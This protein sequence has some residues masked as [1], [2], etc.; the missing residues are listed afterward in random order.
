MSSGTVNA[1]QRTDAGLRISSA[2]DRKIRSRRWTSWRIASLAVALPLVVLL[3]WSALVMRGG[4]PLRVRAERLTIATVTRG[5]FQEF[6]PVSSTVVPRTTHYLDAAEGGRVE[7]VFRE[8]GSLVEQD[9]E[10]LRLGNTNLLLDVMYREAELY[11]Q[12]NNLRNTKIMMEQNRLQ[13]QRELLELD[14]EIVQQQRITAGHEALERSFVS[15]QEYEEARDRLSYL[16]Q[17]RDLVQAA[18][19][20]DDRFRRAQIKQRCPRSHLGPV[21]RA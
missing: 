3:V 2:M 8:A 9:D 20:Q 5:E 4:R 16:R 15:R 6:I 18:R 10:I 17:R 1:P 13:V 21:D 12:S 14:Y 7:E 11:Q 19:E